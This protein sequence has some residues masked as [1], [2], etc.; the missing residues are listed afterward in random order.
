MFR[1]GLRLIVSSLGPW[2]AGIRRESCHQLVQALD[3]FSN[4]LMGNLK[5][6]ITLGDSSG[7]ETIWACCVTCLAHLALLCHLV[8]QREPASSE[9][10]GS[11]CDRTLEKLGNISFEVHI[12]RYSHFDVLTGVCILA[13]PLRMSRA[14][15]G[16]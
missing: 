11:L 15:Q 7:V 6:F 14:N 2:G 1:F 9:S 8:G 10:M 13:V 16:Y 5:Y 12:E 4:S 3:E